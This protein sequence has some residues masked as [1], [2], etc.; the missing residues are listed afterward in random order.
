[1]ASAS[2]SQ[3]CSLI[4]S[5]APT[6]LCASARADRWSFAPGRRASADAGRP[7]GREYATT[8]NPLTSG[9][10]HVCG[11]TDSSPVLSSVDTA[12]EGEPAFYGTRLRCIQLGQWL[13]VMTT[14]GWT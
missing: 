5:D 1:M 14:S 10:A 13:P 4:L 12:Y 11:P 8:R 6:R 3:N 2:M 9:G 7:A